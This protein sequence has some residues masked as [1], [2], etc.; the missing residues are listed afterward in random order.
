MHIELEEFINWPIEKI[1]DAVRK[2]GV[3][4]CVFAVNGTRRWFRLEHPDE[5]DIGSYLNAMWDVDIKI[6]GMLFEHGVD[7]AVLPVFGPELLSRT[8]YEDIAWKGLYGLATDSGLR[9]YYAAEGVQ[10]HFYGAYRDYFSKKPWSELLGPFNDLEQ[11]TANNK[12]YRLFLGACA[13][14]ATEMIAKSSIEFY[15]KHRRPPT[16]KE[17][18]N[19]YYGDYIEPADIFIGFDYF[20]V[21]DMPLLDVGATDLYFTVC[22]SPY[23]TK[24]QL[25]EI[26]Y[27]HIFIR[28]NHVDN[29][30]VA[31]GYPTLEKMKTF[32]SINMGKTQGI[33]FLHDNIWY[34][35]PQVIIPPEMSK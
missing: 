8:G 9:K 16:R 2:S 26:L 18:V 1:S 13:E 3:H 11:E 28:H 34:P 23:L 35:A 6:S 4:V 7:T 33:G 15:Q 30:S 29:D 10:V 17:L 24:N 12:T 27:D 22:P 25:R 20:S 31:L 32:Y 14:D 19:L 21:F 5:T